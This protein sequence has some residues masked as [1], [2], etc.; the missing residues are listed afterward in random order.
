MSR[1][2]LG[3]KAARTLEAVRA[4]LLGVA[5]VCLLGG[6][7]PDVRAP[8]AIGQA[9]GG[10]GQRGG[11][12]TDGGGS[13]GAG[14]GTMD[15]GSHATGA[16][17]GPGAG[18]GNGGAGVAALPKAVWSKSL[19]TGRPGWGLACLAVGEELSALSLA[20]AALAHGFTL[21]LSI[22]AARLAALAVAVCLVSAMLR[23]ALRLSP[24]KAP[25][26][27]RIPPAW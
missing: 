23:K 24:E 26:A 10:G 1:G 20:N 7:S 19:G 17:G 12:T 9:S 18:G 25:A 16:G 5:A 11:A 8:S 21:D 6:C 2:L 22:A 15:G 13:G 27:R 3:R 4:S 14:G